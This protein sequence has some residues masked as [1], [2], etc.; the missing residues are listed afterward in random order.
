MRNDTLKHLNSLDRLGYAFIGQDVNLV[1][2]VWGAN[3][4]VL[5]SPYIKLSKNL[6][7]Y[8]SL[9]YKKQIMD[10]PDINRF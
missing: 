10:N 1:Y 3:D 2:Y 5:K 7:R 6:M 8:L 9:S 4:L